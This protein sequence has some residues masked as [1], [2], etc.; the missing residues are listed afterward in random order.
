MDQ[1]GTD[2]RITFLDKR[3]IVLTGTYDEVGKKFVGQDLWRPDNPYETLYWQGKDMIITFD[4]NSN[5]AKGNLDMS[6]IKSED[7][8]DFLSV[9]IDLDMTK[10]SEN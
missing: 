9:V 7:G 1:N 5:T 4:P 2:M 3:G 8:S 6:A 10:V